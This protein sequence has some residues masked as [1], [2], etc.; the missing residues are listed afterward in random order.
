MKQYLILYSIYKIRMTEEMVH[1][2][3]SPEAEMYEVGSIYLELFLVYCCEVAWMLKVFHDFFFFTVQC[4][5]HKTI[6][7]AGKVNAINTIAIKPASLYRTEFPEFL[8][9]NRTEP[10]FNVASLK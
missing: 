1:D 2:I 8:Q 9:P 3:G 5:N 10:T 7:V 6:T 4:S